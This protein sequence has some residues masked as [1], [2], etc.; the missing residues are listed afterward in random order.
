MMCLAFGEPRCGHGVE[1]V[2]QVSL[3]VLIYIRKEQHSKENFQQEL[4]FEKGS[5][6]RQL[7][8]PFLLL[9]MAGSK[10]GGWGEL[11]EPIQ[12]STGREQDKV[13]YLIGYMEF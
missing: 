8:D 5:I 6:L 2:K 12:I 9:V 7:C 4:C 13:C 11:N 1:R 3:R 10:I